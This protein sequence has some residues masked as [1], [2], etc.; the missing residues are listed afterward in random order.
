MKDHD[1]SDKSEAYTQDD[2]MRSQ[3]TPPNIGTLVKHHLDEMASQ[4]H[5]AHTSRRELFSYKRLESALNFVPSSFDDGKVF[6]RWLEEDFFPCMVQLRIGRQ[7]ALESLREN[8]GHLATWMA[9]HGVSPLIVRQFKAYTSMKRGQLWKQLVNAGAPPHDEKP[10]LT[11]QDV[12]KLMEYTDQLI[13]K[14]ELLESS[15]MKYRKKANET[16]ARYRVATKRVALNLHAALRMGVMT[17]KRPNEI[18]AIK[19]SEINQQRVVLHPSKTFRNGESTVYEMW[20][21]YWPS[22]KA[23]L[24]SHKGENLFSLNHTTLSNW[25]KSLM[26]ACGFEH[27]W[28]NLHR[29]RSFGGD[30]LAMAGANELEMM[31]HGDWASSDS[32]QAYI[33][34]QGRQAN[35]VRASKKKHAFA[36]K[37]GLASTKEEK[38]RDTFIS[39]ILDLNASAHDDPNVFWMTIGD[40]EETVDQ[41]L[42]RTQGFALLSLGDESKNISDVEGLLSSKVVDVPRFELGA[43]TMPR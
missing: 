6:A 25:F 38:D 2:L 34:E 26:V 27:H 1:S 42:N 29:L 41:F 22:F 15:N 7:R 8:C 4:I 24:D 10:R 13:E 12:A 43:S 35:L 5:T 28:F 31:A 39:F 17:T 21:E 16:K 30:A 32:V 20:P 33:S 37:A 18:S 23:L 3:E 11:P 19:R 14:P 9:E 36:K 40:T